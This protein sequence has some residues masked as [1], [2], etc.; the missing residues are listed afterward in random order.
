MRVGGE[1]HAPAA[2]T[3]TKRHCKYCTGGWVNPRVGLVQALSAARP[4]C[5]DTRSTD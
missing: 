3:P 5:S 1:R 2:L 4:A